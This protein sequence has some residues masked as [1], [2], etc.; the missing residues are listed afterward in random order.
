MIHV[1]VVALG[2]P[3]LAALRKLLTNNVQELGNRTS[4]Q[5]NYTNA[6]DDEWRAP[7]ATM[8]TS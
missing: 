1:K 7:G 6:T 4:A 2:V 5:Y 3:P 8:A